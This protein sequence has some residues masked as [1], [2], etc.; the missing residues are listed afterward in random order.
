MLTLQAKDGSKLLFDVASRQFLDPDTLEPL[1]TLEPEAPGG[2]PG[3]G[4]G[5]E[6]SGTG[7]IAALAI[8][9][10]INN[11]AANTA[12]SLGSRQTCGALAVGG[13][14]VIDVTVDAVPPLSGGVGAMNGFQFTLSYDASKVKVTAL[15]GNMLLT[16]NAGSSGIPFSDSVPDTDG[17]LLV[18]VADF[19]ASTTPEGGP[20]VLARITLQ[21][22]TQ[23]SS[24][25]SLTG[26][27]IA[28][29]VNNVYVIESVL[30]ATVAVDTACP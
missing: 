19:G 12:T 20:G 26:V 15:N 27:E 30:G 16:A 5:P 22:L 4:Y 1:A 24:A 2:E 9:T 21:G 6:S 23:G 25:L 17:S 8:D 28:D 3:G 10:D 18:A 13:T 29:A 7:S 11:T 14:L